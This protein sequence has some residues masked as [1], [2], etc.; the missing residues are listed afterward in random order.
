MS[1]LSVRVVGYVGS[2]IQRFKDAIEMLQQAE[3]RGLPKRTSILLDQVSSPHGSMASR[4][5]PGQ[6]AAVVK[7]D[8]RESCD[9]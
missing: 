4:L 7:L 2:D 8:T 3:S 1:K 6:Y 9:A 5:K